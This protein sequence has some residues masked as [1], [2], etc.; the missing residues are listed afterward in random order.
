[1]KELIDFFHSLSERIRTGWLVS[2]FVS[3]L[4]LNWKPLALLIWGKGTVENRIIV[5]EDL[6]DLRGLL[7]QPIALGLV[8]ALIFPFVSRTIHWCV[9]HAKQAIRLHEDKLASERKKAKLE[10][11]N[12]I[13]EEEKL[14]LSKYEDQLEQVER[15]V[16]RRIGEEDLRKIRGQITSYSEVTKDVIRLTYN[17]GGR[18]TFGNFG[19]LKS[20]NVSDIKNVNKPKNKN[21]FEDH[22]YK[23][24]FEELVDSGVLQ[25]LIAN[26]FSLTNNGLQIARILDAEEKVDFPKAR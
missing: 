3:F 17:G 13:A 6:T 8:C 12:E 11:D 26:Y 7:F 19:E 2:I 16:A 5:F 24:T 10:N 25:E 1:M 21:L 4:I 22:P 20:F 18:V 9:G 14:R 23:K 15:S